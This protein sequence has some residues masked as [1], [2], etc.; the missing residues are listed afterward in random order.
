MNALAEHLGT[1]LEVRRSTLYVLRAGSMIDPK[2]QEAIAGRGRS[3]STTGAGSTPTP[4]SS[5]A[6]A[7]VVLADDHGRGGAAHPAPRHRLRPD[8]RPADR[9]RRRPGRSPAGRR[10][11]ARRSV[12]LHRRQ[13][14]QGRVRRPRRDL[15]RHAGVVVEWWGR[16]AAEAQ[17]ALIE[18][19]SPWLGGT[20][21]VAAQ[22][23]RGDPPPRRRSGRSRAGWR[24]MAPARWSWPATRPPGRELK[25]RPCQG[26]RRGR[27][28]QP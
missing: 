16:P 25:A 12:R 3:A 28:A 21:V 11:A 13:P 6:P 1:G 2:G 24:P 17:A 22:L 19:A 26:G 10:A 27:A 5:P 7:A 14:G 9:P 20:N 18:A 8:P 15:P 4:S 23:K